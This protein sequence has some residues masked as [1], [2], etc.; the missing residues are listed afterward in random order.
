LGV[1]HPHDH[2]DRNHPRLGFGADPMAQ[3]VNHKT[4]NVTETAN[5][6]QNGDDSGC[7]FA[8]EM[9]EDNP[10]ADQQLTDH[11]QVEEYLVYCA[12]HGGIIIRRVN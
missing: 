1:G 6:R 7:L 4:A 3:V 2:P 5:N 12:E 10:Q 9:M 11:Q 8:V